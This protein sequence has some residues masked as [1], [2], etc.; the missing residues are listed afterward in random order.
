[1]RSAVSRPGSGPFLPIHL[2]KKPE[3]GEYGRDGLG[4]GPRPGASTGPSE[5]PGSPRAAGG[6]MRI[7]I[8]SDTHDQ[9][10]RTARAVAL[11]IA[12]GAEALFHCGDLT[13]P[14]VVSA[15]GRLPSYFVLG[16]NDFEEDLLRREMARVGGTCL[17]RGGDLVLERR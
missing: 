1:M 6:V 2:A 4:A 15:C 7:G 16:N 14:G 12:E 3:T 5:R 8:L 10:A 17:G 11:L 9:V 13:G